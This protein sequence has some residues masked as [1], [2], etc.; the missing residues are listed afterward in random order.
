MEP[1]KEAMAAAEDWLTGEFVDLKSV[2]PKLASIIDYHFASREA[3][4]V[5]AVETLDEIYNDVRQ[6]AY[7]NHHDPWY[8]K[9]RAALALNAKLE[10]K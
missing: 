6:G 4:R 10:A 7:P 1:S 2:A 8:G 3:A 5:A 9:A